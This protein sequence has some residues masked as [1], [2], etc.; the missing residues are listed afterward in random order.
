MK[1]IEPN[2]TQL[3]D[4]ASQAHHLNA[5]GSIPF[6]TK[7]RQQHHPIPPGPEAVKEGLI[8]AQA[9]AAGLGVKQS[10]H[11][12]GRPLLEQQDRQI[13]LKGPG[14]GPGGGHPSP[15]R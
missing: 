1:G 12:L 10:E 15:E 13:R 8:I 3:V 6:E 5:R 2:G 4:R 7:A 14:P 11:D 9:K